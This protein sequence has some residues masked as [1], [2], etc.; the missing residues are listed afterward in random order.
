[1]IVKEIE[2]SHVTVTL[3]VIVVVVATLFYLFYKKG[4]SLRTKK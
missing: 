1:M 2:V 3:W 4:E